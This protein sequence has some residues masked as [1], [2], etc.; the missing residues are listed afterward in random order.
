[1][2]SLRAAAKA[3][4]FSSG[5]EI[6]PPFDLSLESPTF[7]SQ[8]VEEMERTLAERRVAGQVEHF[9]RAS[10]L[11]KQFQELRTAAPDLSPADVLKQI[12]PADQGL[13]LQTLMLAAGKAQSTACLWAVAGNSLVKTDGRA[14]P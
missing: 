13:M 8:K 6:L 9:E 12:S 2:E 7:Q 1:I 4:A 5:L 10:K 11:L 14:T 3:S